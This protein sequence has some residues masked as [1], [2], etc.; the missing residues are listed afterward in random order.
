MMLEGRSGLG[1][2]IDVETR[3]GSGRFGESFAFVEG[4][5]ADGTWRVLLLAPVAVFAFINAVFS[6]ELL[7]TELGSGWRATAVE[8]GRK[9]AAMIVR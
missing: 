3:D 5:W 4:V 6:F 8:V 2:E 7:V 9:S 1:S